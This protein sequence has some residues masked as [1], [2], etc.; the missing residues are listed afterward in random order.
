[1]TIPAADAKAQYSA[2]VLG[3]TGNVGGR[4]VR[5]LIDSPL[6][7]KVVVVTRRKTDAFTGPKVS[8]VVVDMARL[9]E[10]LA[11]HARGIDIALAAFGVGKG[12]AKMSE[13]ELRKIEVTYPRE[14]FRAAKA[15]GVRVCGVMT[16]VGADPNAGMKYLKII[17]EKEK[18]VESVGFDFLGVYRPS[19]ILGNSNTPGVLGTLMP[20][21]DWALPSKYR[22]IHKNDLA[23]AMVAQSEKAYLAI[24]QGKAPREA[25]VKILEYREM[26][27]FFVEGTAKMSAEP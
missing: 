18:A 24:A 5:L 2:I 12:T 11:P 22:S 1:M 20:L 4:I 9:G 7:G 19:V 13:E 26:K 23:R 14:F 6:C 10:A 16:A 3:A 25:T 21:L 17:G 15:G 8:E 27:P